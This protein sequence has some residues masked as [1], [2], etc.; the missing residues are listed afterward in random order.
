M[1]RKLKTRLP[2]L[3][4][5]K[6]SRKSQIQKQQ[7]DRGTKSLP[8]ISEGSN[9]LLHDGKGWRIKRE[10]L[11]KVE[12]PRSYIVQTDAGGQLRRNQQD[13]LVTPEPTK[14]SLSDEVE[15]GQ[16]SGSEDTTRET[17]SP[18]N[19]AYVTR[20]GRTIKPPVRYTDT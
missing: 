5:P 7:Y 8:E 2:F 14:E 19:Y 15:V 12:T 11:R 18:P 1:N 10:V 3:E 13:I 9:V 4:Q 16:E 17:T 6:L 20:F